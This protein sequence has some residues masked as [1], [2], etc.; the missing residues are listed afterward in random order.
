LNNP[1]LRF[2]E[3][4]RIVLR[5]AAAR[6][7]ESAT[8]PL[9]QARGA[10]LAR[11]VCAPIDLPPFD[12]S[13]MD[14]FAVRADDLLAD[15]E[16]TLRLVGD[17]FAGDTGTLAVGQGE[18]AR[19]TTGAA[20]PAGADTVVIKENSRLEGE[21]VV[22]APG[23]TR[24]ANVRRRG[25]DVAAGEC[26]LAAGTT[27]GSP[28]IGLLAALGFDA[29]AVARRPSVAVFTSGDE[30][31]PAGAALQAGEIYDS[32]RILLQSLLAE[33]GIDT[34]AWPALP[35]DPQR[36]GAAS[37]SAAQAYD[38]VLTCGGVSA[39]EKDLIP[40]LL[41]AHGAVHFWKVAMRPGM[42]VLFGTW[43]RA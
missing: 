19:I 34:L 29:L 39:G 24:G 22:L 33:E 11:D 13:A 40:G 26:V 1:P 27:V 23:A 43:E 15:R 3:A 4:L 5:E 2:A 25:E 42:P 12:N 17:A 28:A 14:G 16:S 7:L 30:L 8:V 6:R 41:R 38:V 36:I 18:C 9:R 37:A 10:V 21:G 31:R 35:D 32:N 20:L